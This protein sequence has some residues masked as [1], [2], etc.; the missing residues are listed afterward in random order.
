MS[1]EPKPTSLLDAA[2]RFAEESYDQSTMRQVLINLVHHKEATRI[3]LQEMDLIS[4]EL[5]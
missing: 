3:L 1:R 5:S 4:K 2:K